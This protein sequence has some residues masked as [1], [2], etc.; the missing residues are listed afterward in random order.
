[1]YFG[2]QFVHSPHISYCG[3]VHSLCRILSQA[4]RKDPHW[5]TRD[6]FR[7]AFGFMSG[8]NQ[9]LRTC[10]RFKLLTCFWSSP[11]K[12]MQNSVVMLQKSV[13]D[14]K[15]AIFSQSPTPD[16]SSGCPGMQDLSKECPGIQDLS[17]KI[18]LACDKDSS[19]FFQKLHI[20]VFDKM[21]SLG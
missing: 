12:M 2:A 11:D 5:D 21:L 6:L 20:L 4:N 18:N 1:M 17:R 9:T 8:K 16:L 15:R 10:V 13:L 7:S 19:F 14:P 3:F